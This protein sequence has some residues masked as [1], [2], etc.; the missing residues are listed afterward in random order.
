M[1]FLDCPSLARNRNESGAGVSRRKRGW[2]DATALREITPGSE[3]WAHLRA[4]PFFPP[5]ACSWAW[6][7]RGSSAPNKKWRFAHLGP[8][9][10]PCFPILARSGTVAAVNG[11]RSQPRYTPMP[12]LYLMLQAINPSW[13]SA[14]PGT[15][16]WRRLQCDAL[17]STG[18]LAPWRSG[19]HRVR[20]V[21]TRPTKGDHRTSPRSDPDGR[22]NPRQ[23]PAL[24]R[25]G[26]DPTA[27]REYVTSLAWLLFPRAEAS[28]A[29]SREGV[30]RGGKVRL[31]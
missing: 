17:P 11:R 25:D 14:T 1:F 28:K 19:R 23:T 3:K 9:A 20:R 15:A 22:P 10:M 5:P 30:G 26:R 12:K 24:G 2:P 21:Q 27:R 4:N 31:V 13:G 6:E 18:F 16:W 29:A 7:A 8:M